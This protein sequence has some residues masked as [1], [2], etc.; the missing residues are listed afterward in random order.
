MA[1]RLFPAP[2]FIKILKGGDFILKA[3]TLFER[4]TVALLYLLGHCFEELWVAKPA[5]SKAAN[6]ETYFVGVGE[7]THAPWSGELAIHA[8]KPA[9]DPKNIC[10]F[11]Q[12]TRAARKLCSTNYCIL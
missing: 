10:R 5:T 6:S 3:Y 7:N 4:P 12:A 1:N 11:Q 8:T 2:A 9:P